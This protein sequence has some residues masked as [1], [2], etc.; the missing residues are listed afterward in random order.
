MCWPKV[1]PGNPGNTFAYF[2]LSM[3]AGSA[4][5]EKLDQTNKRKLDNADISATNEASSYN[6][7]TNEASSYNSSFNEVSNFNSDTRTRHDS[8][9]PIDYQMK[10][11]NAALAH[12]ANIG[13]YTV[14]ENIIVGPKIKNNFL[15]PT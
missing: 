8:D 2:T 12:A 9:E 6:S 1:L 13:K 4:K 15:C 5:D 14:D 7:A 11:K 3:F 10:K